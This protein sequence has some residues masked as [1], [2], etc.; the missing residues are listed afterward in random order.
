MDLADADPSERSEIDV[1]IGADYYWK[2]ATGRIK[3]GRV[4]PTAVETRF[5]W[6]LS[7]P[8]PG[9]SQ[10]TISNFVSSHVLKVGCTDQLDLA[11]LDKKLQAFWD[12]DTMGIRG[13]DCIYS[14]F[15]KNIS[16]QDGRYCVHLPW[17][18]PHPLLP[19]NYELSKDR[20]FNLLR[21]LRQSPDILNQYDAVI[22]DQI[23]CGIV[24][25]VEAQD[26]GIVR[27][28]H[29]IPHHAVIREDKQT[30]KLRIVYDASARSGGPSLNDSL[31]GDIEKAFLMIS[32]SEE[33]RDALRFLWVE[34]LSSH[35]PR[36]VTLRF[37]RV[38]FG[39]S[40][41][42]FL[43]NATLRYHME[44]YRTSDPSFVDQ[45]VRSVYV[46]D[47]TSGADTEEEALELAMKSRQRLAE[48]GF[49]LRRLVTNLPRLQN[50][51]SS[52]E[53]QQS[54]R[55]IGC[56]TVT[57][58]EESYAK[59]TLGDRDICAARI[60]WDETLSEELLIK[61]RELV[62]NLKQ[63]QPLRIP[64][65]YFSG[66]DVSTLHTC[67]LFGFCDASKKAYAAVIFL[68]MKTPNQCMTRFMVSRT[69][70]A[71][72][73]A[74]TIPRLELLAALLL[75]RLVSTITKAV[76]PELI[77]D[78]MVCF[79][80]SKIALYWIRGFSKEWKQF[81]QNRVD[82]I[83]TLV[84]MDSWYHCP[85][86]T[87]LADLPSRGIGLCNTVDSSMWLNGPKWIADDE[88]EPQY[89]D[90]SIPEECLSEMKVKDLMAHSV[91]ITQG[92]CQYEPVI[93][94]EHFS[95]LSHLLRVTA[96]IQKFISILKA[97]VKRTNIPSSVVTALD[98][99]S[100][101]LYW[102]K[103]SQRTLNQDEQFDA[104][105]KQ[106]G[107]YCDTDGVWRCKGRLGNADL[108]ENTKYPI[109]LNRKHHLTAL[110][111]QDC[112]TRVMHNG[113]KETLTEFRSRYWIVR[114]PLYLKNGD[115]KVW[116]CLFT[117]CAVRA[118]HL[119]LVPDL[120]TSAF[121]C[122]L[123]RFSARHGTPQRIV[124][125]NSKTF[126][127]ANKIL[128]APQKAPE[129]QQYLSVSH[130]EWT[131]ILEKAPWW[132]GFYERIIQS[133]KRCMKKVIG[134]TRWTYDELLTV[135]VEVE[136]TLNSHPISYLSAEDFDEPLT[137]SHLLTGRRLLTL[138]AP[139]T[140]EEDPEFGSGDIK[141]DLTRRMR[142]LNRVMECFWRRWRSE[143][144]AGLREYHAY[145]ARVKPARSKVAAGDVVLIYDA[146]QPRT[147][148]RMG[149]VESLLQ[150]SDGNVRGASLRVSSGSKSTLLR[151]T[152]QQLYPLETSVPVSSDPVPQPET[153]V[154]HTSEVEETDTTE[155]VSCP[156]RAAAQ[157]ARYRLEELTA[158]END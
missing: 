134:R 8:V 12:L 95:T 94:C 152:I 117:C 158:E 51:L 49:N 32:V 71:P 5:G 25:V 148:W 139:A 156:R 78:I 98:I 136:A 36:L 48:A 72:L 1:L 30:T 96:Y 122:C 59:N 41:S 21:R 128:L 88:F 13:E 46:D 28:T 66:I 154:A 61:W 82:E 31:S 4:G 115:S 26:S 119:E 97:K 149:R 101:L 57:S 112:H 40:S 29:Y 108:Q 69:R 141:A 157:L 81:V 111:V 137:P 11:S 145:G 55:E 127:S 14:R 77:F 146:D 22:Q 130:I 24:E 102:V 124:S 63:S 65:Y 87:N 116:I 76:Q 3:H 121:I 70:V 79:T 155:T 138:Q 153:A 151:R 106:L 83:R 18:E 147:M 50:S 142:H 129:V 47:I 143:Y 56:N 45:F 64:R 53:K 58:D 44:R 123:R 109:F 10:T 62:A 150:S 84:P 6:V 110:V 135:L 114:G 35:L 19:D 120:T 80:D 52:F 103:L 68:Q 104:W 85:G 99:E 33:D 39:V 2:V 16:L 89:S 132:G 37:A 38:V 100:A 67:T 90:T 92:C 60:G 7:G 43:L 107:L 133:V 9:F 23:K 74:Q 93:T 126:K 34:D 27:R 125:D 75:A 17:K 91:L 144:L 118:V 73:N 113:V 20:L 140:C 54:E 105:Q 131:F 86:E 42:P 15:T